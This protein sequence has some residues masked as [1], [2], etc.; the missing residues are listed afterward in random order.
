[1]KITK[2]DI[3]M[4]FKINIKNSKKSID[5]KKSLWKIFYDNKVKVNKKATESLNILILNA[6]CNGFGDLIFA[7]KLSN[8]IK[9]FYN[10]NV[11]TATTYKDGLLNLGENPAN[12]IELKNNENKKTQCL[13]FNKLIM[14]RNDIKFDLIFVAPLQMD[15]SPDLKDIKSLIPYANILNTFFFSEY[16]DSLSK[17]FTFNT[18]IGKDRD[19]LFL[20]NTTGLCKPPKGLKN[21]Y[22]VIYIAQTITDADL[23]ILSFIELVI[24]KYNKRY[25]NFDIVLPKW[26]IQEVLDQIINDKFSKF[27]PNIRIKKNDGSYIHISKNKLSKKILTFRCDIFPLE[28]KLMMKLIKNSVKE[29]LVTGDQSVTDVLSCCPDKNIFYQIAGWKRDFATNLSKLLPNV[30]IKSVKTS[31]GTLKALRYNSN[32]NKFIKNW[33]FRKNARD[34]LNSVVLSV[35]F[36]RDNNTFFINEIHDIYKKQLIT[37]K[38]KNRKRSKKKHKK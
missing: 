36:L 14:S 12:V 24:R 37:I 19:G 3:K 10:S 11:Y 15:F 2:D 34:K 4:L 6:P 21:P 16:N 23:C 13:K 25:D 35:L 33:D 27:Y 17:N 1:M 18:G 32:Y 38:K 8:Y 30:Y 26:F 20:T 5:I 22:S 29:I 9:H 28:N 7:M 31:C